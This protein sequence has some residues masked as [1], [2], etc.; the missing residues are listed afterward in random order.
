MATTYS[1]SSVYRNTPMNSKYLD[2]YEPPISDDT[3]NMEK[4]TI[5]PKYHNRPDLMSYDLYGTPDYWWIFAIINRSV[6]KDPL[7]D[8]TSGLQIYVPKTIASIGLQ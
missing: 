7:F 6:I 3:T 8:F 2:L 1:K 4:K 5:E